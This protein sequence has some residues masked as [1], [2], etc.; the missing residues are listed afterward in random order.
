MPIR[1][2][3]EKGL[4]EIAAEQRQSLLAS[5]GPPFLPFLEWAK[6]SEV[7]ESPIG[8]LIHPVYGLWHAY[9]GTAVQKIALPEPFTGSRRPRHVTLRHLCRSAMHA[10]LSVKAVNGDIFDAAACSGFSTAEGLIVVVAAAAPPHAP[11]EKVM[12]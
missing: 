2:R 10:G 1:S 9:P 7:T 6:R 4:E 12:F 8:L 3:H 5:T 11:L